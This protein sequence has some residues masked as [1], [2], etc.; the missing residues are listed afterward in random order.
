MKRIL[1]CPLGLSRWAKN[2]KFEVRIFLEISFNLRE[3]N[4]YTTYTTIKLYISGD[5]NSLKFP[6]ILQN[7]EKFA[8]ITST[9][10]SFLDL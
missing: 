5:W 3:N 7:P 2:C 10:Y 8:S 1:R 6:D 9:R 4:I